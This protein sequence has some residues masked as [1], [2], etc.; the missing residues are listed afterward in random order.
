MSIE[1]VVDYGDKRGSCNI[2]QLK[3]NGLD[4]AVGSA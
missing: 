2:L 3:F 4:S 1:R